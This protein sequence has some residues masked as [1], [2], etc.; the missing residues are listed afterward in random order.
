MKVKKYEDLTKEDLAKVLAMVLDGE[1]VGWYMGQALSQREG[2]ICETV[3][4]SCINHLREQ[5][6]EDSLVPGL[7]ETLLTNDEEN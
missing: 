3:V 2:Q 4:N 7:L 6:G 1:N 5:N